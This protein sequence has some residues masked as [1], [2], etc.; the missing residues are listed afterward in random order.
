ML[1]TAHAAVGG[2][3]GEYLNSPV[4]AFI[5]GFI[6]HFILDAI[7]HYDTTDNQKWTFRQYFLMFADMAVGF[8]LL[9]IFFDKI[10]HPL[11]F[12]AGSFGS[13]L[14]DILDLPPIWRDRFRST[15]FGARM[16]RVH[17]AVQK[18]KVGPVSGLSIQVI[19]IVITVYI[20]ISK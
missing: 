10:G 11:S 15:W 9:F 1:F 12:F 19:I 8:V 6:L 20:L 7:P 3:A 14:P 18:I 16:H 5:A 13:I 17:E 2:V 4:L